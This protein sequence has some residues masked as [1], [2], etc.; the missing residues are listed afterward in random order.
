MTQRHF[1]NRMI[2]DI[3][4]IKRIVS[5]YFKLI[6]FLSI[7][8]RNITNSISLSRQE[9]NILKSRLMPGHT[10]L[11]GSS[12]SVERICLDL[13]EVSSP[14]PHE[15][16]FPAC[17]RAQR[18]STAS[19]ARIPARRTRH[20]LS[21]WYRLLR[22]SPLIRSRL[23]SP[24]REPG[25]RRLPSSCLLLDDGGSSSLSA[26]HDIPMRMWVRPSCDLSVPGEHNTGEGR[27]RKRRVATG[28]SKIVEKFGVDF[29]FVEKAID[30]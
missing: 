6:L 27:G 3:V 14:G 12:T 17:R 28:V 15:A 13:P 29:S 2:Y 21:P 1:A 16:T 22:I 20:V 30:Q 7:P 18:A 23:R 8:S 19:T 26:P 11:A 4:I 10:G 24:T 5:S 25:F 9:K